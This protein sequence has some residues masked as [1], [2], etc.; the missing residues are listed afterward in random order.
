MWRLRARSDFGG[1][2]IETREALPEPD[3]C[4]TVR[5]GTLRVHVSER[6]SG[7]YRGLTLWTHSVVETQD[8]NVHDR[9]FNLFWKISTCLLH[10]MKTHPSFKHFDHFHKQEFVVF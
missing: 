10:E 5:G 6:G 8:D 2:S 4:P 7:E 9:P 1:S 3:Q